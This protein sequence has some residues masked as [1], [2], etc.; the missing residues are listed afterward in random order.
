[1]YCHGEFFLLEVKNPK[2]PKRDRELTPAQV[3]WHSFWPVTVVETVEEAFRAI[4]VTEANTA[5]NRLTKG[6]T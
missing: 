5:P 2:K 1:V 3:I 4:Y 6:T